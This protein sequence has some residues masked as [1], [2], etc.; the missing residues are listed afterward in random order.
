MLFLQHAHTEN[1]SLSKMEGFSQ[2]PIPPNHQW[3]K[4][5]EE[6]R[7]CNTRGGKTSE[8]L[9]EENFPLEALR[10]FF[11]LR[12]PTGKPPRSPLRGSGIFSGSGLVVP[13]RESF[14]ATFS[15]RGCLGIF[16]SRLF[17]EG[18]LLWS[19][20]GYLRGKAKAI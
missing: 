2:K 9:S 14:E 12:F 10:V 18:Y 4:H 6:E 13:P 3:T 11:L 1:R 8:N 7:R 17:F 5:F 19:F 20:G 16:R 15:L